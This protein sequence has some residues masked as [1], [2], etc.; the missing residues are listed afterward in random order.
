MAPDAAAAL[1]ATSCRCSIPQQQDHQSD[2]QCS[3][4]AGG[5]L[6]QEQHIKSEKQM[7]I[8]QWPLM[9]LIGR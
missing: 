3:C 7:G 1:L 4:S 9:Q 8:D 5:H 2:S 6:L